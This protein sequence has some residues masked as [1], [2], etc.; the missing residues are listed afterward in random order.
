[1][2]KIGD[3]VTSYSTGYWQVLD[4]KP[5]IVPRDPLYPRDPT[6]PEPGTVIGEWII[7]KKAFTPK[8]KPRIAFECCDAVWVTP[9]GADELA[10]IQKAFA[11]DP[12]Y[13]EKFDKVP[14]RLPPDIVNCGLYLREEEEASFRACMANLPERY[15]METF[16]EY[17]AAYKDCI[18]RL[19]EPC[20]YLLNLLMRPWDFTTDWAYIYTGCELLKL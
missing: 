10:A 11:D 12:T 1:M 6:A 20:N 9:V 13:Q 7:L 18:A 17:L 19:G 16:W 5:K 3:F 15:T 8:M 14:L 2:P 4:R